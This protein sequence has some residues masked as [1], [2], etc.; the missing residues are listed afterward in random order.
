MVIWQVV[1]AGDVYDFVPSPQ[2]VFDSIRRYSW[3]V[4]AATGASGI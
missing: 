1:S 2:G 3:E 4:M